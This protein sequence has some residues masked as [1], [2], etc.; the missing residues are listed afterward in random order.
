MTD[1]FMMARMNIERKKAKL[2]RVCR[3]RRVLMHHYY[4][5]RCWNKRNLEVKQRV[6]KK[7]KK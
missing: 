1:R 5:R 7:N 2:C 4:C 6:L 3:K